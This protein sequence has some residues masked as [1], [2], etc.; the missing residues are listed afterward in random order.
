M[1]PYV[2]IYH[3]IIKK[4]GRIFL[5]ADHGYKK[6]GQIFSIYPVSVKHKI[7][8]VGGDTIR[9]YISEQEESGRI[10]DGWWYVGGRVCHFT[11]GGAAAGDAADANRR[12]AGICHVEYMVYHFRRGR[13]PLSFFFASNHCQGWRPWLPCRRVSFCWPRARKCSASWTPAGARVFPPPWLP[14][15]SLTAAMLQY[16]AGH[17]SGFA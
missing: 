16:A 4:V 1:L 17:G 5:P 9:R 11:R 13:P 6:T 12:A 3:L 14:A 7:G 10:E 2:V 15:A 8:N